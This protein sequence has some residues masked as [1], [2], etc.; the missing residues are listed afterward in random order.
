MPNTKSAA[1]E[2]KKTHKRTIRNKAAKKNLKELS[3]T[4][5]RAFT[6][7]EK[8]T[9]SEIAKKAIKAYDRAASKG[10]IKKNTAARKKSRIMKKVN[11]LSA[12]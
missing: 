10:I 3:K 2:L 4:F 9:T 11:S 6:K 5:A 12:A 1:K 7:K 8:E